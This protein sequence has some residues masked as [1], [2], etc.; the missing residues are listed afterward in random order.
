MALSNPL[1]ARYTSRF[2]H[3]IRWRKAATT[4]KNS[5]P[6]LWWVS[7]Q[8]G[9]AALALQVL[10]WKL[11]QQTHLASS[12]LQTSQKIRGCQ[13]T[14][15][16]QQR[17]LPEWD[18]FIPFLPGQYVE[19]TCFKSEERS[20]ARVHG[21]ISGNFCF[22]GK[23]IGFF[24]KPM[25]VNK[26][27]LYLGNFLKVSLKLF[28]TDVLFWWSCTPKERFSTLTLHSKRASFKKNQ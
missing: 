2:T 18:G 10:G 17:R 7:R 5:R 27:I 20:G 23:W 25:E 8:V 12:L 19:A 16:S 24:L 28:Q 13:L 9:C 6:T 26:K 3:G 21:W 22:T 11:W 4:F 1:S 14:A 15:G